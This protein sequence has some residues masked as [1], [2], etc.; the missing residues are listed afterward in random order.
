VQFEDANAVEVALGF[1]GRRFPPLLPRVLRVGRCKAPR[2][3][4]LK[5][6][7]GNDGAGDGRA[8]PGT[9]ANAGAADGAYRRK[10]SGEEASR[11]GRARKVLGRA[12]ARQM[13]GAERSSARERSEGLVNGE[14]RIRKPET[15]VFEGHRAKIK[16]GKAG[17]KFGKKGK[18]NGRQKP[19]TRSAKRGAAFKSGGKK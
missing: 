7:G 12:A 19:A 15:F 1:E 16:G 13:V 2:K 17:I 3:T 10:I 18:G 9:G 11:L 14:S 4:H 5:A 6:Q 8:G